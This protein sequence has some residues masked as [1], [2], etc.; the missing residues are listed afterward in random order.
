LILVFEV[1]GKVAVV[2]PVILPEHWSVAVGGVK[3]VTVH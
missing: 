1:I 3:L 2:V